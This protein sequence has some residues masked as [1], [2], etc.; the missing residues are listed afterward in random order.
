MQVVGNKVVGKYF[1][2]RDMK[3]KWTGENYKKEASP[4]SRFN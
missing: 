1:V 2:V 4:L 3:W